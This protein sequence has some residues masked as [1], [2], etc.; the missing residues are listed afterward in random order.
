MARQHKSERHASSK[1]T[2]A[3][4]SLCAGVS[5]SWGGTFANKGRHCDRHCAGPFASLAEEE[6]A[7]LQCK[8]ALA[9]LCRPR[10]APGST[11]PGRPYNCTKYAGPRAWP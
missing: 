11:V 5:T 6:R 1:E 8:E 7:D 9:L 10:T 3:P 2:L 4:G